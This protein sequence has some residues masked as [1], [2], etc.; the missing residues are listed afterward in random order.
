[1]KRHTGKI[2]NTDQRCVVV[3]M[4]VPGREDHA[5]VCPTDT[6][7]PRYEQALRELVDSN[8]GQAEVEIWKL[9]S[10][11]IMPDTG[12]SV[13]ETLHLEGRLMPVPV[14]NI[15][16]L[17]MPN[18]PF[19]L[20]Q[21]LHAMGRSTVASGKTAPPTPPQ[22]QM[23]TP[24]VMPPTTQP[25]ALVEEQKFNPHLMNQQ[26]GKAEDAS[27][28]AQNLLFEA[29]MIEGDAKALMADAASKRQRAYALAPSLRPP[30]PSQETL[31]RSLNTPEM[32]LLN[33]PE[34]AVLTVPEPTKASPPKAAKTGPKIS[35][36]RR[37]KVG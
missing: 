7:P 5:L 2:A 35:V 31:V 33:E 25:Q 36:P 11:R 8:E 26:A 27:A 3:M 23:P 6:L 4:Q 22:Q 12:R 29:S 20:E 18:K 10:R 37:R 16:M 9:L 28:V 14:G 19:P 15:V 21:I 24:P 30:M 34:Q 1:M 32:S 17:P 13:M